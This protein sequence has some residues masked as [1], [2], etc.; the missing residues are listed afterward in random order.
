MNNLVPK[1][2]VVGPA[3]EMEAYQFTSSSYVPVEGSK[4][5]PIYNTQLQVIVDPRLTG[6]EWYLIADPSQIDT[7]EYSFLEGD[8]ELF[9]E[10]RMGWDVD[11]LELKARMVFGAKAIDWRG[12]YKNV[13]A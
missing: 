9:T 10:R 7:I 2:L 1:Y 12:M 5:N 4:I 8:G 6:N 3:K 13:G 11:G